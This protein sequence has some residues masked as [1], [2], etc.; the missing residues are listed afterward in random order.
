MSRNTLSRFKYTQLVKAIERDG[1]KIK[2][3]EKTATSLCEEYEAELD[4]GRISA[5]VV[6]EILHETGIRPRRSY[7]K[8]KPQGGGE[9]NELRALLISLN[10]RVATCER[11]VAG[12][13]KQLL[14]LL[15]EKTKPG[16][17]LPFNK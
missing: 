16:G 9:I 13:E 2:A 1:E 10:K 5:D 6:R 4:V 14:E 12:Q 7:D 17:V 3:E 8:S 15:D 11:I